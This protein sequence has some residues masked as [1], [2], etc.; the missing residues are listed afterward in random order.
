MNLYSLP[1]IQ[2]RKRQC[3]SSRISC[4]S[5][6][7][8]HK[9]SIICDMLESMISQMFWKQREESHWEISEASPRRWHLSWILISF[10]RVHY[11]LW[12]IFG[13]SDHKNSSELSE[14]QLLH[15]SLFTHFST[16]KILHQKFYFTIAKHIV[17]TL[18]KYI[19]VPPVC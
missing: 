9:Y 2:S 1:S 15:Y 18:N 12:R 11:S 19:L 8:R 14:V 17:H 6:W 13:S 7:D 10:D 16:T 3:V 5:E 4:C